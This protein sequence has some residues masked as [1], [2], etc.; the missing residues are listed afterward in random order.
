[1]TKLLIHLFV[2][3]P[4]NTKSPQTRGRYISLGAVTGIVCNLLLAA[5][6]ITVGLLTGS[7]GVTADGFNNLS[8]TGSAFITQIGYRLSA[9]PGDKEHPFGH[10]RLEYISALAVGVIIIL[11]GFELLKSSISLM[12]HPAAVQ[13]STFTPVVLGA[14]ILLKLWMFFF[15]KKLG[16]KIGSKALLATAQDSINDCIATLAVLL[17]MVLYLVTAGRLN[18][19]AY[20][21]AAV[22]LFILYSGIVTIKDTVQ[23]LLGMPPEK[24][25]IK[26]I[27][28]IVFSYDK[29]VGIH[30]LIVHNY[31][32]GRSFASLHI[33]V[34]SDVDLVACHEDVDACERRIKQE[35]GLEIVLH[36]DPIAV[37]DKLTNEVRQKVASGLKIIDDRL[38]LHDFRMVDG[39]NNVNLIFDVVKPCGSKLTDPELITKIKQVCRFIDPRYTA[40]VTVDRE[41]A[42][43][44]D[45]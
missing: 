35:L 23:P 29:F 34:P 37:N 31:G 24:E 7:A 12:L 22:A 45:A 2:K 28:R 30:D 32:P 9:K 27:D 6:K 43:T 18:L 17:C 41:Y 5:L 10:G 20:V 15:Q 3:D 14:S 4:E 19:D 8:D 38:T 25:T 16:K 21:S 39:K 33:E 36:I 40:V 44:E 42:A 1:M 13:V 26:A 11:V